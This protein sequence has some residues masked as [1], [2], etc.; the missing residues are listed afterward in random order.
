MS[1]ANVVA[2]I[3]TQARK[4]RWCRE[5]Y[6]T[7]RARGLLGP[8]GGAHIIAEDRT[9]GEFGL[10][11]L[12]GDTLRRVERISGW[13]LPSGETRSDD[14]LEV[15]LDGEPVVGLIRC[16]RPDVA[17]THPS[18][19]WAV[20]AGFLGDVVLPDYVAAGSHVRLGIRRTAAATRETL[21]DRI[22]AV[23]EPPPV[24]TPRKTCF[25]LYEVLLDPASGSP[26]C[27]DALAQP[28]DG[29]LRRI[30]GVPHFHPPGM[31]PIVRLSEEGPTHPY[32]A[33]AQHII[34]S[35]DGLV[36][37]FGAGIQAEDRLRPHVVNLDAIHFRN[38]DVVNSYATLPF[39]DCTFDSVI[40]QAV[41]EHL[42][43][44]FLAS[45]E[46]LRVLKPG[47]T[48]L[49][50]TAFMQPFHADPNHYFNMTISGLRQVMRGFEIVE[51]GVQ[52]Y[53]QPSLGLLMQAETILPLLGDSAWRSR[54]ERVVRW[55]RAE[56]SRLDEALGPVGR[57]VL[58]AGVY[59]LARKPRI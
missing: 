14:R 3:R 35:A 27:G 8:G 34:D 56:G 13:Y 49:I 41:F 5:F 36:L 33:M 7:L 11:T 25:E 46:I 38:I 44:P 40:S 12:R 52:P 15:T 50:D 31:Q 57:E 55:L 16:Y 26:I 59:V 28:G 6:H 53:Q 2:R 54:V 1:S 47:G 45:R 58:A 18:N 22:F 37:D 17:K 39:R 23:A 48:A 21:F 29:G 9:G 10:E 32:S 43:D 4:Y 42:A 51:I 20:R 24:Y 19:A 30:A